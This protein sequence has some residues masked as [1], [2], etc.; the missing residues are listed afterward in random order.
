MSKPTNNKVLGVIERTLKRFNEDED[1]HGYGNAIVELED[2]Y[3]EMKQTNKAKPVSQPTKTAKDYYV[4]NGGMKCLYCQCED[5]QQ[6]SPVR[7]FRYPMACKIQVK[8]FSCNAEWTD[9]FTLT[10]VESD[11]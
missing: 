9:R 7:S 4:E 1:L 5:I 11:A 3:N 8:C 10:G 6:S 2:L